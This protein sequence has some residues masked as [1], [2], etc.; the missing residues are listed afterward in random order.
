MC[1]CVCVSL[2]PRLV[3]F[4]PFWHRKQLVLLRNIMEGRYEFVSPEWDDISDSAKDLVKRSS[5]TK[6][7]DSIHFVYLLVFN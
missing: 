2:P 5:R 6:V 3:G 1:V 7:Q 4:P